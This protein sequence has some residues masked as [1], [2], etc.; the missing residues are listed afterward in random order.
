MRREVS[1]LRL[2]SR[3]IF[4]NAIG[5]ALTPTLAVDE[6]GG[7]FTLEFYPLANGTQN[8]PITIDLLPPAIHMGAGGAEGIVNQ[9]L[10]P[11]VA[12]MLFTA[13][14]SSLTSTLWSGGPKLQD[15]LIGA[16]IAQSSGGGIIVNPSI[17]DITT[18]ITGLISTLATGVSVPITS[19][20]DL[21]LANDGGRLGVRLSGSQAFNVGDYPLSML[22]GAPTAWGADFDSGAAVYLFDSSGGNFTFNPGLVVAGLGLGLTGQDDAPLIKTSG[23]RLGGVRLYSFFHGEFG[24]GFVF[25]SPGAGVEL[26]GL[27]LPLG[28]ATGGNVGGNNP[29]AASLLQSDG[30][31][32]NSG[33]TQSVNPAVDVAAWYWAAPQGDGS[34][35]ILFQDND[36]PIWIGV[37][38]QFG[39]I[40]IDQI[41]LVPNGNTSVSLV[42]DASVKID[43]LTGE[44][45]ELGVTIPYNSLTTPGNWSLDLKGIALSFQGPEVTIA[46]AL[47]KNDS[48]PAIEYD[49]MLLVQV[50]EFGIVAVGAYS[51]PTDAQG[52]YTSIFIFAGVFIVI[53]IPPVDRDRR[54]RPG[55][56]LQP[57][58]DRS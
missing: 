14:K 43:G 6:A 40:Y 8:G 2:A 41:G 33:D 3:C 58:A 49:G 48:G 11:L 52:G 25:D 36:Q 45:D 19:T 23:F 20:L 10:I 46:G 1:P 37:H 44:V 39:P 27:G 34:F 22:F 21:G 55:R 28:Q 38:A 56:G 18:I 9:W 4:E 5:I 42:L 35:H 29:V 54:L 30:G 26:D 16:H 12:D 7:K 24:S 31:D 53:G 57:R 17:P 47:L 13:T 51:K 32:N 15:V 50:T